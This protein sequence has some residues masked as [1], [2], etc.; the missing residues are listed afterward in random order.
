MQDLGRTML[1]VSREG[2]AKKVV[3]CVD[4]EELAR[5]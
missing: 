5:R 4:I 1:R 3:E 2:Y